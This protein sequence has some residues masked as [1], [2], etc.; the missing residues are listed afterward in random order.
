[1]PAYPTVLIPARISRGGFASE[2]TY[3][4]ETPDG[5]GCVGLA[6]WAYTF[7]APNQRIEEEPADG[8][9][10]NGFVQARVIN[11]D[12]DGPAKV[13]LPDGEVCFVVRSLLNYTPIEPLPESSPHVPV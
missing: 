4:I 11:G 9:T 2:R 1:M 12:P 7:T 8:E 3:R 13:W 5:K 6:P 10:I